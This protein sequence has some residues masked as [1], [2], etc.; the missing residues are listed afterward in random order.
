MPLA[1]NG[2]PTLTHALQP[3]SPAV[4]AGPPIASIPR[5]R[6]A[7]P[8]SWRGGST[9]GP[10]R[11]RTAPMPLGKGTAAAYQDRDGDPVRIVAHGPG[12][13]YATVADGA[14]AVDIV[15]EGTTEATE[16]ADRYRRSDHRPQHPCA[17]RPE[18]PPR[19]ERRPPGLHHR[20]GRSQDAGPARRARD[21]ARSRWGPRP[22][23]GPASSSG[24]C[25][26][27]FSP[28][29]G[30]IQSLHRR[31]LGRPG[32][33]RPRSPPGGANREGHH[34]RLGPQAQDRV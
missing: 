9:A 27:S 13:G 22:A 28:P 4:N 10:S 11:I 31:E 8:A 21:P 30:K 6:R 16:L 3:W 32:G 5:T 29:R 7:R 23:K 2:G 24:T 12:E 33:W 20:D 1:D 17:R 18:G 14:D 19:A 26:T 34:R 25:A 15:L